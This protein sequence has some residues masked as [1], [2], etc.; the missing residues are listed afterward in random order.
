MSPED[1]AEIEQLAAANTEALVA[2]LALY[3]A[4]GYV[5]EDAIIAKMLEVMVGDVPEKCIADTRAAIRMG[6]A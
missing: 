1:A 3:R 2:M 4:A 5:S 6:I